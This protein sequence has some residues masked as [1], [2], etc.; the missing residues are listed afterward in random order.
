MAVG[1]IDAYT[2]AP[3]NAAM[4]AT[5]S[6]YVDYNNYSELV[7]LL[8]SVRFRYETFGHT[9]T[10]LCGAVWSALYGMAYNKYT[11]K[12]IV[13]VYCIAYD[14]RISKG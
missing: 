12:R 11:Q 7:H 1:C 9:T 6:V 8:L 10:Q 2:P 13:H 3:Q 14:T 4:Y 5:V